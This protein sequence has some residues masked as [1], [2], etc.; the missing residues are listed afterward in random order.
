MDLQENQ[1]KNPIYEIND[2][3]DNSNKEDKTP[4]NKFNSKVDLMKINNDEEIKNKLLKRKLS[5]EE[6]IVLSMTLLQIKIVDQA[7]LLFVLTNDT[8]INTYNL[9]VTSL[10]Y[11]T[12]SSGI[13][14]ETIKMN[15]T[16]YKSSSIKNNIHEISYFRNR[17]YLPFL[18]NTTIDEIIIEVTNIYIV[19]AYAAIKEIYNLKLDLEYY[20]NSSN[21]LGLDFKTIVKEKSY[22]ITVYKVKKVSNCSEEFKFNL[23][24]DKNFEED[25]EKVNITF[26]GKSDPKSFYSECILSP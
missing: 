5:D 2:F 16:F 8:I 17:D 26:H 21:Q 12:E 25:E 18:F 3:D 24:L 22:N 9:I 10:I 15:I 1:K 13:S 11:I 23:T 7:I 6:T 14:E 20:A 4:N 19:P